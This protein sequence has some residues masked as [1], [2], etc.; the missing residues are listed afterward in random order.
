MREEA[1]ECVSRTERK[2][3]QYDRE[4]ERESTMLDEV[5]LSGFGQ[6]RVIQPLRACE[7]VGE[8]MRVSLTVVSGWLS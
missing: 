6:D 7:C 3:V 2:S 4:R 1:S 8:S 5:W